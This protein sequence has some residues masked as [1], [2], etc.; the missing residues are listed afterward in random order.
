MDRYM[1]TQLNIN[2]APDILYVYNKNKPYSSPQSRD[3]H[4]EANLAKHPLEDLRYIWIENCFVYSDVRALHIFIK[5][6]S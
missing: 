3:I 6:L 4:V 1:N 2:I 5:T